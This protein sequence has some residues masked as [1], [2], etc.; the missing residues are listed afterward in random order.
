MVNNSIYK[1]LSKEAYIL[2]WLSFLH[3]SPYSTKTLNK[4]LGGTKAN[5]ESWLLL[6]TPNRNFRIIFNE[7]ISEGVIVSVGN[8]II[9]NNE[10]EVFLVNKNKIKEYIRNSKLYNLLIRFYLDND[11]L[12]NPL[13]MKEQR[14][15]FKSEKHRK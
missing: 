3:I 7:L 1:N 4:D 6:N 13:S 9:N 10:F 8:K 15:L 12:F 11:I 2:T 14:M 5:F